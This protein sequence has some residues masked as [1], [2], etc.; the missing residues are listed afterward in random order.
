LG[1][2]ADYRFVGLAERAAGIRDVQVAFAIGGDV[3]AGW[4]AA[5]IVLGHLLPRREPFSLLFSVFAHRRQRMLLLLLL[6]LLLF[7]LLL[8]LLL[9]VC[10]LLLLLFLL[11]GRLLLSRAFLLDLALLLLRLL[12]HLVDYL[13]VKIANVLQRLLG[14][15]APL[16]L[17]QYVV[18][19]R[20]DRLRT[21][22]SFLLQLLRRGPEELGDRL[23]LVSPE[24]PG[25]LVTVDRLVHGELLGVLVDVEECLSRLGNH[26]HARDLAHHVDDLLCH[27]AVY[28]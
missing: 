11:L 3:H 28:L 1:F 10:L 19:Y 20:R 9:S 2:R 16:Y 26:P 5:F 18:W 27:P 24:V 14:L 22:L 23:V 6:V 4:L 15:R 21:A 13:L 12:R 25:M 8:L 17:V 7:L